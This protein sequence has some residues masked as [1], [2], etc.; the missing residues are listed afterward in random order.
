MA[1]SAP[2]AV[3]LPLRRGRYFGNRRFG[4]R[5]HL[6]FRRVDP[7]EE[8]RPFDPLATPAKRD[9]HEPMD[10]GLLGFDLLAEFDHHA[11]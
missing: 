8:G 2:P 9:L 7:V 5:R 10:V 3:A 6:G 4:R 11:A 1:R